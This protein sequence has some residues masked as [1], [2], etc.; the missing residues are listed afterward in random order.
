MVLS[1]MPGLSQQ[2]VDR[3]FEDGYL[4]VEN[5]LDIRL[6]LDPVEEE[7]AEILE[8]LATRLHEQGQIS[9]TFGGLPV[10]GNGSSQWRAPVR[11]L[12]SD[13]S[14]FH[15]LP[16][17]RAAS[18]TNGSGRTPCA[19]CRPGEAASRSTCQRLARRAIT[20]RPSLDD[21]G[22]SLRLASAALGSRRGD[23]GCP[24]TVLFA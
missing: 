19:L 13:T 14:K 7:Y 12:Y 20:D 16:A 9:E 24:L 18:P 2:Q 5:A 23:G 8:R 11:N 22:G 1:R 17:W 6:D 15:S 21:R 3:L 10:G 4:L